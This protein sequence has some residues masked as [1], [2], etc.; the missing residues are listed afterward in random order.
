MR[1]LY[2]NL[3]AGQPRRYLDAV[4]ALFDV[5]RDYFAQSL[6]VKKGDSLED[7]R[8]FKHLWAGR[9]EWARFEWAPSRADVLPGTN[10][11]GLIPGMYKA[12]DGCEGM[13][14]SRTRAQEV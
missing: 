6:E 12:K 2:L 1:H 7:F 10:R 14:V 5:A 13:R 4:D 8:V 9:F 11:S 3:E